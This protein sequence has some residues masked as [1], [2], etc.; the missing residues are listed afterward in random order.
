[1]ALIALAIP[2]APGKTD[3]WRRF[4]GELNGARNAEYRENRARLGVHERS[5]L[6]QTP[7]GDMAIITVEGADPLGAMAAFG[8]GT[9]AFTEWF[10]EQAKDLHGGL[11]LRA[12]L[13]GP[14]PEMVIDSRT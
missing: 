6:Q 1:M 11:D 7:H 14:P 4:V 8:E 9:D 12:A 5:F 2:I 10:I 3:A 13:P